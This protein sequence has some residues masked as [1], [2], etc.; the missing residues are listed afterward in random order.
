MKKVKNY[1]KLSLESLHFER[2]RLVFE[3]EGW[4][5]SLADVKSALII[6]YLEYAIKQAKEEIHAID[7]ELC[8]REHN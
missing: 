2:D 6:R 8:Y 5:S 1:Q 7:A 4:E 3:I